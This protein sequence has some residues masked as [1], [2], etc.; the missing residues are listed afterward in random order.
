MIYYIPSRK[1]NMTYNTKNNMTFQLLHLYCLLLILSPQLINKLYSKSI[2]IK[3]R[4]IT[5]ECLSH[6]RGKKGCI[7]EG[8]RVPFWK[9]IFALLRISYCKTTP[10][11]GGP[12]FLHY[13]HLWKLHVIAVLGCLMQES[14]W[15]QQRYLYWLGSQVLNQKSI[16]CSE[17][18]FFKLMY[19]IEES[20]L[21]SL[22]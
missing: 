17:E 2:F 7:L 1:Q 3:Y 15:R 11:V 8:R 4:F 9:V 14:K 22:V 6:R 21:I 20:V 18:V 19:N 5:K 16:L 13:E 12:S 10:L